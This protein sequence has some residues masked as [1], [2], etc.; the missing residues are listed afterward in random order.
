MQGGD[1]IM[2]MECKNCGKELIFIPILTTSLFQY[3]H[4]DGSYHC[5][6]VLP[7]V[8]PAKCHICKVT[9]PPHGPFCSAAGKPRYHPR[10]E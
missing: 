7:N 6:D 8:L 4:I 5:E 3:E 2:K 9:E 10:P 1:T